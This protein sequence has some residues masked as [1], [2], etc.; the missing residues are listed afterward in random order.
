MENR[1]RNLDVQIT[2]FLIWSGCSIHFARFRE[3]S[4]IRSERLNPPRKNSEVIEIKPVTWKEAP[5]ET[6]KA[7]RKRR[8]RRHVV[9]RIGQSILGRVST[10]AHGHSS[11][12]TLFSTHSSFFPCALFLVPFSPFLLLLLHP[13]APS[14]SCYSIS[15]HSTS[16]T[17][18]ELLLTRRMYVHCVSKKFPRV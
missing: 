6:Q 2:L 13:L 17:P 7:T 16:R 3:R 1:T 9:E 10:S 14:P 11:P 5:S 8:K 4:V 18:L 12:L 15:F